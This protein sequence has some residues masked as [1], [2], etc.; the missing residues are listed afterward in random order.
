M[1]SLMRALIIDGTKS[2]SVQRVAVP[3]PGPGQV[4]VDVHRAGICGTDVEL[5]TT[6]T[7][8]LRAGQVALPAVPRPRVVRHRVRHRGGR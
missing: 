7:G 6:G 4:V 1:A 3:L 5:F 2:A 8:V